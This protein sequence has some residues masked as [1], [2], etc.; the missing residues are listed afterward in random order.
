M[1]LSIAGTALA[2][3]LIKSTEVTYDNLKS[4]ELFNNVQKFL[5]ELYQKTRYAITAFYKGKNRCQII[6]IYTKGWVYE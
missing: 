3:D 6:S 1:F 5:D 2:Q 4:K